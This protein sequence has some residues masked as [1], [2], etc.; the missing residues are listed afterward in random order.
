MTAP[1]G[2]EVETLIA[3]W[4]QPSST[5]GLARRTVDALKAVSD[6]RDELRRLLD[7]C[8]EKT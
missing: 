4:Y 2:Q 5:P 7:E 1:T 8:G 3:E 6:E